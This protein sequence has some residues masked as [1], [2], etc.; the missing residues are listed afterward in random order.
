VNDEQTSGERLL[1]LFETAV[2]RDYDT[3]SARI[4]ALSETDLASLLLAVKRVHIEA[5]RE[6]TDRLAGQLLGSGR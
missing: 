6:H 4:K 3:M 5:V 1:A 2:D